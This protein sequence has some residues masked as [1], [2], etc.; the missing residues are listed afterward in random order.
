MKTL[1]Q[2]EMPNAS[3]FLP[4]PPSTQQRSLWTDGQEKIAGIFLLCTLCVGRLFSSSS[5]FYEGNRGVTQTK[6]LRDSISPLLLSSSEFHIFSPLR[7]PSTLD[8]SL[9][10]PPVDRRWGVRDRG[11][12]R[13]Y[14]T[15]AA[16]SSSAGTQ[17]LQPTAMQQ[18][19][20]CLSPC[21]CVC[22]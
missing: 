2:L 1:H 21:L 14:F 6:R 3:F 19:Q 15:A 4:F 20:I 7:T 22:E 10:A 18:W 11:R 12:Q 5:V 8:P 9:P 13:Q 16:Q 17:Y